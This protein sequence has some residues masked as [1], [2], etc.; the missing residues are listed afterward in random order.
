[1]VVACRA[2]DGDR[3]GRAVAAA[4]AAGEVDRGL[5]DAASAEVADGDA[6]GAAECPELDALDAVQVHGDVG[7]V[8]GEQGVRAVRADVDLLGDVRA[9]EAERVEPALAVDAVAAGPGVPDE[10]VV[11]GAEAGGAAAAPACDDVV[12]GAAEE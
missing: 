4:G 5:L 3:V 10:D 6:V 8:A 12:A 9:V 7:D 1:M 11:A 2:V